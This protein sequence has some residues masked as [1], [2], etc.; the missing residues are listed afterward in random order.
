M[1]ANISVNDINKTSMS[2]F[3]G[4]NLVT[5]IQELTDAI[6]LVKFSKETEM[7]SGIMI[8]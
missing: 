8:M 7:Y 4:R 6:M 2:A 3:I 1:E 5:Q